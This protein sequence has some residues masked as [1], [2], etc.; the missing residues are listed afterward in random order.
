MID[1]SFIK[2]ACE[3]V[4]RFSQAQSWDDLSEKIKAQLSFNLGVAT[5]GLN[6][7]KE[8]SF[9]PLADLCQNKISILEFR[10]HF[11]KIIVA[12]GVYVDQ[13]LID[14]PF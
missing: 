2:H 11:E 12:K 8:D 14:R 3:Q 10:E 6:I 7:S 5:L 13:E 9:V 4:L 1:D